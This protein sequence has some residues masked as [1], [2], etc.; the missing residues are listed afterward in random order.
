MQIF[1]IIPKTGVGPVNIGMSRVDVRDRLGLPVDIFRDREWHFDFGMAINYDATGRV[2]FIEL[3]NSKEFRALFFGKCLHEVGADEAVIFLESFAR[4]DLSNPELGYSYVFP[5]LQISL[6]RSVI[7]EESQALDDLTGRYF[8]AV[9]VA[10]HGYFQFNV[11]DR[12][13]P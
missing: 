4:H 5:D 2:E 12:T 8:E 11:I 3:A 10:G 7:P 6:W 1:D 9:G 13:K